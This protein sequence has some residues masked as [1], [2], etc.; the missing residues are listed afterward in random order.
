MPERGSI[1]RCR[2]DAVVLDMDGV[3]TDT[4]SVHAAAWKAAFDPYLAARSA[5]PFDADD[6]YRR[7]VDGRVRQDGVRAFL[8]ARGIELP[9]GD[10]DGPPGDGSV[11][12]LANRK[13]EL[14]LARVATGGVSAFPSTVELLRQARAA[15]LRTALVTASRNAAEILAAAGVAGLFDARVDGEDAAMLALPGKPDP[16]TY[17]EAARRL[18][19]AASRAVVVEDALAGVEAAHQ[20]RPRGRRSDVHDRPLPH[21]DPRA[22]M[23]PVAIASLAALTGLFVVLDTRSGDRR[24]MLAGF[25]A[26]RLLASRLTVTAPAAT[27][28]TAVS[29]T[30]AG[31]VFDPRQWAVYAG[32]NLLIAAT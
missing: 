19:V 17:L 14:F 18:G 22:T 24:L 26:V 10:P 31:T 15:G 4:A 20:A 29:L 28:V 6:E 9:E 8:A 7:Y 21:P 23:A 13:N 2:F 12:A 5:A 27:L 30:A 11:W 1:D 32:A 16:A 3:V 25:G